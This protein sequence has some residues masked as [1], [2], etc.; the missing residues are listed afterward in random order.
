MQKIV[1]EV[2][3]KQKN[4]KIIQK[5]KTQQNVSLNMPTLYI[6]YAQ[7]GTSTN[8]QTFNKICFGGKIPDV[9]VAQI[10]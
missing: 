9:D 4:I 5:L 7:I 6:I 1:M 10:L 2:V 3:I 8:R